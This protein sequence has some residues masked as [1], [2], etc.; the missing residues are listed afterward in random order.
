MSNV[1]ELAPDMA[2][3]ATRR[4]RT[5]AAAVLILGMLT[6]Y[7]GVIPVFSTR[8][9]QYFSL[10]VEQY[11]TMIGLG[12]LGKIPALLLVGMMIVRFGVRRIVELSL[13]GIGGCF[14]FI[15]LGA[16]LLSL[17]CSLALHGLFAGLSG[18]AIPALLIALFPALK[19]QMISLQLVV[20]AA[21][22]I[23][24]PLWANQLLQ[25][26]EVGGDRAFASVFFGPYLIVGVIVIAGGV[27]LGLTKPPPSKGD[28]AKSRTLRI[29]ELFGYR[30]LT[31][32]L[33]V[34][35]HASADGTLFSF[36]PMFMEHHFE[37][38]PL[39]PAWALAGHSVAYLI[40]RFLLSLLPEG[41][42]QRK[43]LTLAGP[44]GGFIILAMLWQS[45]AVSVPLLY[46]LASLLYA[47]EFPVL[48]SEISSR[49]MGH[50]GT[51]LAGGLLVGHIAS[52]ALLKGMGRLVDKTGDYRLA[53]SVAACG[54][55][56]FGVIAA[57]TGLG[58]APRSQN[59]AHR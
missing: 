2:E 10:S 49:S 15:G 8:I 46:T 57:V 21:A 11:G 55:I 37:K 41:F 35:L 19:R 45:H 17:K 51:V 52:F 44:I 39:A 22:G 32:V 9:C 30:S 43:I 3:P 12:G 26:S 59:T 13:V 14:V 29:R 34:A 58:K 27:L 6:S 36:L 18:V 47:A 28:D 50:F 31:I 23:V 16:S 48:V 56:A 42:G 7:N 20:F 33:L 4:Q 5:F 38:L 1:H 24:V 53:L 25:W 40:T 54:F